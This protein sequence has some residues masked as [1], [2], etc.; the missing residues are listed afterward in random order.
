MKRL[1]SIINLLGVLFFFIADA[2]EVDVVAIR[3][4]GT[5]LDTSI[6][7]EADNA[8]RLA[9][10]WLIARQHPDGSWGSTNNVAELTPIAWL[11]LKGVESAV[12]AVRR[13]RALV[14]LDA[15][16]IGGAA[17]DANVWRRQVTFL[18][19]PDSPERE[20]RL[21]ELAK[22]MKPIPF[23][24]HA[25][26]YFLWREE[27]LPIETKAQAKGMLSS[28]A[29]TYPM[30]TPSTETLWFFARLINRY[31]NGVWLRGTEALDW[32][33]DFGL[34]LINALRKDPA[35]GGY[36][37]A[38]TDDAKIRATAFALLALREIK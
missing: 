5:S 3:Q 10:E 38:D 25:Y 31:S 37:N 12:D 30:D 13:D 35:G 16:P 4:P 20:A 1:L 23:S 34:T 29:R 17:F 19:L 27:A 8:M 21:H 22:A 33:N 6:S 2:A 18:A 11:A 26:G 36:W 9:A 14:W 15:Q 32:R 7:N 28:V 24:V